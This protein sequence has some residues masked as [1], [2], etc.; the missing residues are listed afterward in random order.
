[1]TPSDMDS[2]AQQL[3]DRVRQRTTGPRLPEACRPADLAEALAIQRRVT[4]LRVARGERTGGW[5]C[6]M[7][8]PG[9]TIVAPMFVTTICSASPCPLPARGT[10]GSIEPEIAFVMG[11]DLPPRTTPY[12]AAEVRAAIGETRLVLEL[13][14]CRYTDPG[15][16]PFPEMLA[17]SANHFGLFRGPAVAGGPDSVPETFP[18]RIEGPG[19]NIFQGTGRHPDGNPVRPLVWL[20]NF[21]GGE[22]G[23]NLGLARGEIVTTGSY[24]GGAVDLPLDAGIAITY[25]AIGTLTVTLTAAG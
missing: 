15:A 8:G 12:S 14:G 22:S 23:W 7:P 5:K 16:V 20:A 9:K 1:M 13:M 25:G 18:L 19:G 11:R 4:A 21:L 17:D 10:H 6:S 24:A 2:A 3:A